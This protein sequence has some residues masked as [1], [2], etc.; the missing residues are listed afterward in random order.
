METPE[1]I[2][3]ISGNGN[4]RKTYYISGNGTFQSTPRKCLTFQEIETP[5]KIFTFQ[6]TEAPKEFLILPETKL[7]YISGNRTFLYFRKDIFRTLTY[8]E[9]C[10]IQNLTHI[11]NTVK[12]L[13]WNVLPK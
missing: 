5:K 3:C 4:P 2:P 8:S 13:E 10:Y 9:L 12:H 6:E 1:E 7:T 11:K